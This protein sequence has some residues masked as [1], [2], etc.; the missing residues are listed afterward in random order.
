MPIT[1]SNPAGVH[2]PASQYSHAALVTGAGRRLIMSGQVGAA[3]DG[4]VPDTSVAQMDQALANIGTILAAHGMGP[5]NLVKLN[6]YLLNIGCIRHWRARRD[7][8]LGSHAPASTLLLVSA[9]ADPRFM[10][11]I[12]AEAAD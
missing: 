10:V 3:P 7:A 4:T 9:L 8:F 12:E 6:V 2:Q 1:L 11:E 5:A